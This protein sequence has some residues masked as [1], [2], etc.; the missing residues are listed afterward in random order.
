MDLISA[1]IKQKNKPI[2]LDG[3]RK[4]CS[5]ILRKSWKAEKALVFIPVHKSYFVVPII[6]EPIIGIHFS[7]SEK[8]EYEFSIEDMIADDWIFDS[9]NNLKEIKKFCLLEEK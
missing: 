7:K 6:D 2:L 4:F 5:I 1:Q 3:D 9:E 8:K